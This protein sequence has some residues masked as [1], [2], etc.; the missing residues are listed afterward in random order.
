MT[1]LYMIGPTRKELIPAPSAIMRNGELIHN[2]SEEDLRAIGCLPLIETTPPEVPED[3]STLEVEYGYELG[4]DPK[5]K[6]HKIRIGIKASYTIIPPPPTPPKPV[7]CIDEYDSAMERQLLLERE[8]RGYT[9][10]EPDA[11]LTSTNERW[12]QDAKD[13]VAHRDAVM[14][15]ALELINAVKE[16][17][18]QPPTM[19][20]FVSGL[21]KI[22]WT[23]Q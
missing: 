2:P 14:E 12:A 4:A 5:N 9:T 8:D 13:W 19:E 6:W 15:Y 11:Y 21:P 1:K 3:G 18:R 10:R 16:G 22:T 20:E 23:I 17:T 7:P